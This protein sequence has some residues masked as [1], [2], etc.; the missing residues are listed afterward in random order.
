MNLVKAKH[1]FAIEVTGQKNAA[2]TDSLIYVDAVDVRS[3]I[4]D[5]DLAITYS[6]SWVADTGRNWSGTSLETGAGTA[7]RSA[8]G[9]SRAELAFTGT[10]VSLIGFRAPWVGMADV[11]VD[12][13]AVTRVDLYSP[14]EVVQVPVFSSTGLAAGSHTLRIDVT[15]QKNTA[16]S[17]AWVMGD[18]FEVVPVVPAPNVTRRQETDPSVA[19]T[20][21]W[22]QAGFSSLW[23]GEHA[24]QSV[25]VGERATFTFTGTSVRW[26][27]ERGFGTGIA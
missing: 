2:A 24:R 8:T 20:A 14:T 27:G 21:G 17:A 12:G 4:E 23:S 7:T 9:G 25:I 15:G 16:S 5:D 22:T 3:R 11:S 13:G 1:S 26:I 6:G 18:A 19:F 10:S